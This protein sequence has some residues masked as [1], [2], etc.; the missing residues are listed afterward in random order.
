MDTIHRLELPFKLDQLTEGLGNCF[1][2]AIIQQLRRP[3]ISCQL[4]PAT[5]RLLKCETGHHLL[6]KSVH[7]FIIK[8]KSPRIN[9]LKSQYEETDGLVGGE[10]WNEYWTRMTIDRTWV[11]YWFVQATAWYLQLDIWIV[12]TSNTEESPYIEVNGNLADGSK[13]SHGPMIT[14]G[15][16]SN[17][18]FQSILP[19]EMLHLEFR[20]VQINSQKSISDM[21]QE[22]NQMRTHVED[23]VHQ[24]SMSFKKNE[25]NKH[26]NEENVI[27]DIN[28]FIYEFDKTLLVYQYN[29]THNDIMKCPRC[30]V[31]TKYIIRHLSQNKEC[32]IGINQE[33]FRK[34]LLKYKKSLKDPNIVRQKQRAWKA[35][36]R[37]KLRA[38]NNEIVKAK[39][40]EHQAKFMARKKAIDND[41]VKKQRRERKKNSRIKM[42]L[43]DNENVKRQQ[44]ESKKNSIN[45]MRL[46]DNE[47]VKRQQRERKKN[48][49]N[50]M[51]LIDNENVKKQHRERKK[52]SIAEM[53]L[54]DNEN[55]K[56]QQNKRKFLSLC[57]KRDVDNK[58]VKLDQNNRQRSARNVNNAQDRLQKFREAT[59]F[60][61]I[62]ICICCHQ[63][64][65]ESNVQVF[66][67]IL[68]E[69]IRR[70]A[71]DIIKKSIA[72]PWI[73]TIKN[74]KSECFICKTCVKYLK[75]NKMPPMSSLNGLTL[76]ETDE[77]I[78]KQKLELT[79]L[80]GALISKNILFQKI[81]QL[82]KSRWTALKDRVI[83]VPIKEDSILNTLEQLPRTPQD[84]GL[85]GV[86]LKRKKEYQNIHKHQLINPDK[87]FKI[88]A[89]LKQSKNPYYQ[90]YDDY[91][92]YEKRC[93]ISDPL[94]YDVIF[95]KDYDTIQD[96]KDMKNEDDNASKKGS[97]QVVNEDM[98]EVYT[99]ENVIEDNEAEQLAKDPVKKYQFKYNESLCMTDKYPE[100]SVNTV[101]SVDVAPGEDQ[102]PKDIMTDDDWDIK[103]FPHLHNPDGTNGKDQE[104]KVKLTEQNYFIQRIC[105]KEKRFAKSAAYTYAAVAYIEKKQITR[106]INLAGTRG[107]EVVN[108]EGKHLSLKMP[109]E[110]W[111]A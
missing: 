82:P 32:K 100:I 93:Q 102:V 25:N 79:E 88:L 55:V 76:T 31:E 45:A 6:R 20:K 110:F 69:E 61:A 3:E 9:E 68:Q 91:N 48:S 29:S 42:R 47:N 53:R 5:R 70:K 49:I 94:G 96:L 17:S 19:I 99:S 74:G 59:K 54:L 83:N 108:N 8:S 92:A 35:A 95:D 46:I 71:Q 18:H 16:K 24:Q 27:G 50:A 78:K 85:I 105:N 38:E 87:L 111:R 56:N 73:L 12:A 64:M 15:T 109:I 40:R 104:R 103:A 26:A 98:D 23:K 90:F 22:F 37:A 58:R 4:R 52:N 81:F 7:Q 33:E 97:N 10:T 2:I 1:P 34:Q 89:K 39:N 77:E 65:F 44:R 66:N 67:T 86:A 62:F 106:N 72:V 21:H 13:P 101:G 63:R 11:D 28:P 41:G 60:N 84:A 30:K 57:R 75:Q 43:I 36:R 80:E 14:L 107:K 51:R